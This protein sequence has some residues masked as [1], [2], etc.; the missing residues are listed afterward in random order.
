MDSVVGVSFTGV[1]ISDGTDEKNQDPFYPT[2]GKG[3]VNHVDY[4]LGDVTKANPFYHFYS[5]SPCMV[6]SAQKKSTSP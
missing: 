2:K 5:F 1:P 4:C 6:K 3:R